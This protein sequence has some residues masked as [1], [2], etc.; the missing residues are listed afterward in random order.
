MN[1]DRNNKENSPFKQFQTNHFETEIKHDIFTLSLSL[2]EKPITGR[3]LANMNLCF[4]D[5]NKSTLK[6]ENS[7]T[8]SLKSV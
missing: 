5:F 2:S 1:R 7:T 3:I 6:K 4:C 8:K